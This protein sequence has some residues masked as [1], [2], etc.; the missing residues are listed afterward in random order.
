MLKSDLQALSWLQRLKE[1]FGRLA[2]WCLTLQMYDFE[3]RYK[4]GKSVIMGGPDALN[5]VPESLTVFVLEVH[6]PLR[7][8]IIREQELDTELSPFK[9]LLQPPT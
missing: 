5:R 3:I 4:P 9:D 7:E 2:T 6:K 8:E 1:P